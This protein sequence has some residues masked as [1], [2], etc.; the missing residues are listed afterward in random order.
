MDFFLSSKGYGKVILGLHDMIFRDGENKR[1]REDS[2]ILVSDLI[3]NSRFNNSKI[4]LGSS[5]LRE[6]NIKFTMR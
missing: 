1:T 5:K 3:W 4:F 6:R 2:D